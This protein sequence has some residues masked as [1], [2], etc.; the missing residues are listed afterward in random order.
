MNRIR[1]LAQGFRMAAIALLA[2]VPAIAAF[3]GSA[4]AQT[5]PV[6]FA[7]PSTFQAYPFCVYACPDSVAVATGDFN[8]DGNLDVVNID[9]EYN[10]NL[11]LGNGNGTF[12]TATQ[13]IL[14]ISLANGYFTA[15]AIA[16]GDFNGDGHLDVAVWGTDNQ[17]GTGELQI[18]L[19]NGAG[20]FGTPNTYFTPALSDAYS[21]PTNGLAVADVNHDGKLDVIALSSFA[22]GV[23]VFRGNG[24]GT[25]QTGV[26]YSVGTA[27]QAEA[28]SIGD[29]NNDGKLD[30][31]VSIN[32][33]ISVLLNNGNGTFAA[34]DYYP[35]GLNYQA[36]GGLAIGDVN[37][38]KK[39]DIV[40]N[41]AAG[42]LI[43]YVNQ[44]GGVFAEQDSISVTGMQFLPNND[45]LLQD[46]N[47]DKKL[48]IVTVD[49][50]GDVHTFYG[51]GTGTFTTGPGYP[52]GTYFGYGPLV[53]LG[54]FNNDGAL[55]LLSTSSY[56]PLAPNNGGLT[57]ALTNS[58]SLGRGN[59]T[60]QTAQ[61]YNYGT[62]GGRN[63]VTADFNGDGF[64][65]VAYSFVSTGNS[66]QNEDFAV[67]LGTANG[68]FAAPTFAQAGSCTGNLTQWIAAAD[69]NGDGKAD[70]VASLLDNTG[71]GCQNH[72]LAVMLG[73]GTGAFNTPKY[74]STGSTAQENRVYLGDVNGDGKLDIVVENMDGTISVLLNKGNGTFKPGVLVSSIAAIYPG[75]LD[76]QV[77]DFNGDGKA[78]I[79]A[80]SHV[81]NDY[82]LYND[83]WVLLST[84][85]GTFAAPT[86][87]VTS[88]NV[89]TPVAADF[90]HDGKLDLVVTIYTCSTENGYLTGYE[91]IAGNGDGTFTEETNTAGCNFSGQNYAPTQAVA[92]DLNGD[93][94]PDVLITYPGGFGAPLLLQGNGDGTFSAVAAENY[95]G[96]VNAGAAVADFNGDGRPDIA[97]LTNFNY[98]QGNGEFVS[99]VSLL[100]N[101]SLP[102]SVSPL[103]ETFGTIAVGKS[104]AE[105]VVL[106][107]DQTTSVSITGVKLGGADAGDFSEKS[108][109]ASTLKAGWQCAITVTFKPAATGA[110]TATLTLTDS[111]GTQA[112]QLSGTGQ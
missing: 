13:P 108:A 17:T 37:G 81:Y 104:K 14:S 53:A 80:T 27:G 93:G 48:D 9:N 45:L 112:V 99:Y 46:I 33:G 84:G 12:G 30:I 32:V 73:K 106:T 38:D 44:G 102:L 89:D 29:L 1:L 92:A 74:Y 10:L 24:D 31:A 40:Q 47:G 16:V 107:N 97:V 103:K 96:G 51:Q 72:T 50:N 87:L 34:P 22:Q 7:A 20:G 61:F 28:L 83:V 110:R 85:N 76:L 62:G 101:T 79:V 36:Y 70:M 56:Y 95:P 8:H 60:F 82:S 25:F 23:Y 4:Q 59:G 52:L 94:N 88:Y 68:A 5:Q 90:N 42:D 105:T 78:D 100:Q 91:F 15:D 26:N 35:S 2:G 67:L 65:D 54:D 21:F 3:M 71:A 57:S 58:V 49:F 64:P 66:A 41:D 75:D 43:V 6:S 98:G 69:L 86:T 111:T 109:C 11:M 39:L 77:A 55:D 18:L 63:I 19:G